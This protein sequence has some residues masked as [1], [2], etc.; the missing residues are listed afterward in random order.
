MLALQDEISLAKKEKK[1]GELVEFA[2]RAGPTVV[3][4]PGRQS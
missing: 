2:K 4:F 1:L 3:R